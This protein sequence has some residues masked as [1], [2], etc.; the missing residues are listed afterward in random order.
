M[1]DAGWMDAEPRRFAG[2]DDLLGLKRRGDVDIG[3]GLVHEGIAHRSSG[4]PRLSAHCGERAQNLLQSRI[5]EPSLT[6]KRG[7]R[8][9]VAYMR[10]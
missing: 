6:G 5:A 4:D 10:S 1:L 9:G 7:K 2:L 8:H 3:D